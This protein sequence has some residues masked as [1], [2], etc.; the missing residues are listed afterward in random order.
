MT[1]ITQVTKPL[2]TTTP[3]A[4]I[5]AQMVTPQRITNLLIDKGPLAIRHITQALAID[6]PHFKELSSSKQ[7]RLI[8]S[9]LE[10]GDVENFVIFKKIGWG[11]WSA[12]RVP[13]VEFVKLRD[14]TNIE[15]A[16]VN[17]ITHSNANTST[18]SNLK[19]IAKNSSTKLIEPTNTTSAPTSTNKKPHLLNSNSNSNSIPNEINQNKIHLITKNRSSN[20]QQLPK[21]D[22][23]SQINN[24][25]QSNNNTF[26]FPKF[27][28]R[29][30]I[31]ATFHSSYL[32]KLTRD[33]KRR[34]SES[35]PLNS[36]RDD[37]Q[38]TSNN[39]NMIINSDYSDNDEIQNLYPRVSPIYTVKNS[40][41]GS[42]IIY[43]EDLLVSKLN[44]VKQNQESFEKMK[45]ENDPNKL[46]FLESFEFKPTNRRL[47]LPIN[48]PSSNLKYHEIINSNENIL[49]R[50]N[51][52]PIQIRQTNNNNNNNNNKINNSLLPN[53]SCIRSTLVLPN[54]SPKLSNTGSPK[55]YIYDNSKILNSFKTFKLNACSPT[56]NTLM[57][58]NNINNGS[59]FSLQKIS[60]NLQSHSSSPNNKISSISS[61]MS[62]TEEED[63]QSIGA[64]NM[65]NYK[66]LNPLKN[67]EN[68]A[69]ENISTNKLNSNI[70]N[71]LSQNNPTLEENDAAILLLGLK[72]Q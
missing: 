60:S 6:I 22:L 45:Q 28:N 32:D 70:H 35:E 69:K 50:N 8:M 37:D 68:K 34:K 29:R 3:E 11:N 59:D 65:R 63:W 14:L 38:T 57:N 51:S 18:N 47:S 15:N 16:K 55:N 61:S 67:I 20:N 42:S 46:I 13:Q 10:S 2:A 48:F 12:R 64:E 33:S 30:S 52:N 58:T 72:P 49:K 43:S 7:R 39:N 26:K 23:D 40:R 1:A 4:L 25:F 54:H 44:Q 5:A 19:S 41:R 31:D 56:N 24:E 71:Q 27:N 53:E 9:A 21:L 62:D 36:I 17:D 66:T